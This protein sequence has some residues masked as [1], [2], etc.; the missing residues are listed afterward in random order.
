MFILPHG[1]I[2]DNIRCVILDWRQRS[3]GRSSKG[4]RF[5][6]RSSEEGRSAG[7]LSEGRD[8][9]IAQAEVRDPPVSQAKGETCRLLKQTYHVCSPAV[10]LLH[11]KSL[12]YRRKICVN[13]L[14]LYSYYIQSSPSKNE[15]IN[16]IFIYVRVLRC[17]SSGSIYDSSWVVLWKIF[18]FLWCLRSLSVEIW[19]TQVHASTLENSTLC[20]NGRNSTLCLRGSISTYSFSK[21]SNSQ[22]HLFR[23]WRHP[24]SSLISCLGVYYDN[25]DCHILCV[26]A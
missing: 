19:K 14:W 16:D 6:C 21:S 15:N 2:K 3:S 8:P 20:L 24:H 12:C 9:L 5:I 23:E 25:G 18:D 11:K 22:D 13:S 17:L 4:E 7:R 10:A 1:T 26:G